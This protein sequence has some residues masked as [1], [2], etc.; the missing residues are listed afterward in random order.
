MREIDLGRSFDRFSKSH[1]HSGRVASRASDA[2]G[3]NIRSGITAFLKYAIDAVIAVLALLV[4]APML[5]MLVLVLLVVQGRPIFIAHRRIGRNGVMFPCL[6]FRTM[7]R[8]ADEVLSR[9]LAASPTLRSEWNA[10]RKLR[11]DPRVTPLG[12]LLRKSS[13]D[14][15][16]QLFNVIR[17]QMSLVGPRPIVASE[18]E[19]YGIY[20]AEYI[21]VRPGLTG[22]WQVSGRSDTSYNERVQLDV[23]YV[24]EQS[25]LGDLAIMLKTV[26]AVLRSRGSY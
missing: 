14:E 24:A 8:N 22:L 26:P 1:L 19:L 2:F 10:S 7:V 15:I 20:F 9:H 4:L 6:K 13:I 16:P 23:R 3:R 5:L 12:A 18:A 25:V 21:R 11:D 17:G